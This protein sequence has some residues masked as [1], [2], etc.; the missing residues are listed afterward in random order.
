MNKLLAAVSDIFGTI[1]PPAP[2]AGVS[3][4]VGIGKLLNTI[5][6]SMI[7]IAGIYTLFNLLFAG[8]AFLSAG[9]DPKKIQGA[10]ARIWQSLLGLAIT[11][12]AFVLAAIFGQL[13]FGKWDF[14]L[15]PQIPTL[16]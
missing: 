9:E 6:R 5:F 3:G 15:K 8:Y 14:I 16:L 1:T 12:G 10:W 2:I 11:A 4:S 13:I 7:V